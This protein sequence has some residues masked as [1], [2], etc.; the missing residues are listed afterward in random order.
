MALANNAFFSFCIRKC[1]IYNGGVVLL[2][3][4]LLV[5]NSFH[6][7]HYHAREGWEVHTGSQSAHGAIIIGL[8]MAVAGLMIMVRTN[9]K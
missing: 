7:V 2:F 8:I 4:G 6:A 3:A 1:T 9:D 5:M